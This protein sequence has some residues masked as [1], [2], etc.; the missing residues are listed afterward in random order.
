[1]HIHKGPIYFQRS[2][3]IRF[4]ICLSSQVDYWLSGSSFSFSRELS[5]C[6]IIILFLLENKKKMLECNIRWG[7]LLDAIPNTLMLN[8]LGIDLTSIEYCDLHQSPREV[9][10]FKVF[11]NI[12]FCCINIL[13]VPC[14]Q[15]FVAL[16]F[17]TSAT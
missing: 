3:Q 13:F 16:F 9:T 5:F 4:H 1:M 6:L 15:H 14:H 2:Y 7:L 17:I 12:F 8:S 10:A 11:T